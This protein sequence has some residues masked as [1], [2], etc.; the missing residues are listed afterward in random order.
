M[1]FFIISIFSTNFQ[2][3]EMMK[4][5]W[6]A[7]AT[8]RINFPL[9]TGARACVIVVTMILNKKGAQST[10]SQQKENAKKCQLFEKSITAQ[11]HMTSH[12]LKVRPRMRP[13]HFVRQTVD[14]FH[15]FFA[16]CIPVFGTIVWNAA[17]RLISVNAESQWR[18]NKLL[19][20]N[21]RL[22]VSDISQ[23][24]FPYKS[25]CY[26]TQNRGAYHSRRFLVPIPHRRES[27]TA[28]TVPCRVASAHKPS[29]VKWSG[30]QRIMN[31]LGI[32]GNIRLDIHY[33]RETFLYLKCEEEN[34][35]SKNT[36]FRLG[37]ENRTNPREKRTHVGPDK[38]ITLHCLH[39]AVQ[40]G[41]HC[42]APA[43]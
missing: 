42:I 27:L 24:E 32:T 39:F 1:V 19:F 2:Q 3:K 21:F 8:K 10:R 41:N 35:K 40:F 26:L 15:L 31:L 4:I 36:L 7:L 9:L 14:S 17:L 11:Q 12:C 33:S 43:G 25:V 23:C 34:R 28:S 6:N 22:H 20:R 18:S 38:K 5:I 13:L 30:K 29:S 37:E 16:Y